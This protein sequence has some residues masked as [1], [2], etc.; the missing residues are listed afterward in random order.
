MSAGTYEELREHVGHEVEVVVYANGANVAA[1]CVTCSSV[2]L[3]YDQPDA[4]GPI[5][6]M[7]AEAFMEPQSDE[8]LRT[9][10]ARSIG[11]TVEDV[12][13]G[14]PEWDQHERDLEAQRKRGG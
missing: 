12:L 13:P 7:Y 9:D 2:L 10:Y 1:E 4:R 14:T 6:R 8:S 5:D 11:A 3:D